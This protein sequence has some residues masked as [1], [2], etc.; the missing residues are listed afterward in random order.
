MLKDL[1]FKTRRYGR[2][3][4]MRSSSSPKGGRE[5]SSQ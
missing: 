5:V 4:Q 1:V 3:D 2:F